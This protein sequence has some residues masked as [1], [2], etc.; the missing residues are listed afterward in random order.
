MA[1]DVQGEREKG[2]EM[3]NL[4]SEGARHYCD[5]KKDQYKLK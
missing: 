1:R 2:C 4:K 5:I 3:G